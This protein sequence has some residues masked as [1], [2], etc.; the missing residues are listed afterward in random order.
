[1]SRLFFILTSPKVCNLVKG[2]IDKAEIGTR[3]VLK[4]RVRSTAQNDKMWAALTDV[5]TQVKWHG[6]TLSTDDWKLVFMDAL[7]RELRIV[8]NLDGNGFVNI[9]TSSSDLS[10]S[11]MRDLISLIEAFGANHGVVFNDGVKA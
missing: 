10:V 2:F 7:K 4:E 8:P 1:M 11:E 6:Q 9:G 5:A 3:V